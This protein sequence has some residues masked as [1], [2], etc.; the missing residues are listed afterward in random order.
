[1]TV[2]NN[3]Q[4]S[5]VDMKLNAIQQ[6]DLITA[7]DGGVDSIDAVIQKL[8]QECPTAFHTHTTLLTRVFFHRPAGETPYRSFVRSSAQG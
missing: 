2:W 4:T 7:S 5:G 6:A 1:M 8:K 3:S